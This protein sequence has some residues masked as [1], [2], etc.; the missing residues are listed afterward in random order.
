MTQEAAE[1]GWGE[2][3]H[4]GQEMLSLGKRQKSVATPVPPPL[5]GYVA[6]GGPPDQPELSAF[7]LKWSE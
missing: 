1:P 5:P 7:L 4:N 6:L 3:G 2:P